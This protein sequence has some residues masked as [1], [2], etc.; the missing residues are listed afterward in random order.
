MIAIDKF[1]FH[2]HGKFWTFFQLPVKTGAEHAPSSYENL[3]SCRYV[4][5]I[6]NRFRVEYCMWKKGTIISFR[7]VY[8]FLLRSYVLMWQHNHWMTHLNTY[9]YSIISMMYG[10]KLAS[11]KSKRGFGT[12]SPRT[13]IYRSFFSFRAISGEIKSCFFF[14]SYENLRSRRY[15]LLIPNRFRVEYCMRKK[16]TIIPL[17]IVYLFLLRSYVLM[18]QHNHW[19]TYL[20]NY[21]YSIISMMYGGKLAS[22]KSKRGFGT[23]SPRTIISRDFLNA[24]TSSKGLKKTVHK[25]NCTICAILQIDTLKQHNW[26]NRLWE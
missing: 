11:L 17:C 23:F 12:F 15:V 18:W 21:T 2:L 9:T 5:L 26:W 3:R 19:M 10:G 4:L 1:C 20:N 7:I 14:S 8:L 16:G 13:I 6:P 22:L 25:Y 24:S